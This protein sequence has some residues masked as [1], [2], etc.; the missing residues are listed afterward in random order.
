M[1]DF[2]A[3]LFLT[4][5]LA[6]RYHLA[7]KSYSEHK[8]LGRFYEELLDLI[9]DL[10]EMWQGKEGI[11]DIPIMTA[12]KDTDAVYFVASKLD[13]VEKNRYKVATKEDTAIQNKIDEIVELFLSTLYR[14][15]N[16]K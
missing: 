13:Y 4:R 3:T 14:L 10:A 5:E 12:K 16:L 2:L 15:E 8:A 9:D 1:G 11:I 7:T 6:H